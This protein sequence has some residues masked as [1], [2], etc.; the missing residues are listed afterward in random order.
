MPAASWS[1][2]AALVPAVFQACFYPLTVSLVVNNLAFEDWLVRKYLPKIWLSCVL[3]CVTQVDNPYKSYFFMLPLWQR[4]CIH[5]IKITFWN[6]K[7]EVKEKST[8]EWNEC[9]NDLPRN[10]AFTRSEP[11]VLQVFCG[12]KHSVKRIL[13]Y[14]NK[15]KDLSNRCFLNRLGNWLAFPLLLGIW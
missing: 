8:R 10:P 15:F 6:K 1:F 12:T 3:Y 4:G 7:N 14:Q 9:T 13:T 11:W 2:T 5:S